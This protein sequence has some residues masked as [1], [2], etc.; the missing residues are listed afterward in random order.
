VYERHLASLAELTET[1]AGELG[2]LTRAASLALH[3]VVQCEK[4][5]V[6]QLAEAERHRHVH[7]HVVPR[8]PWFTGEEV[9]P[10]CFHFLN[11]GEDEQVPVRDRN[12]LAAALSAQIRAHLA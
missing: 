3:A 11:V 5:Y 7:F 6:M 12:R 4:T 10:R 2:R 8:M 1:E 9:G